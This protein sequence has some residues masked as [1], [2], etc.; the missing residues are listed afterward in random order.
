M[1]KYTENGDEIEYTITEEEAK[2]DDLKFYASRIEKQKDGNFKIENSINYDKVKFNV[3]V[4]KEVTKIIFNNEVTELEN[5]KTAKVEIKKVNIDNSEIK[6]V[7]KIRVKNEYEL[8]AIFDLQNSIPEG[9]VFKAEN[10]K[11]WRQEIGRA[12]V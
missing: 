2:Q 10:N 4:E 9:L 3:K 11:N 1:P 5:S 7:Y 12:H 8:D 6:F